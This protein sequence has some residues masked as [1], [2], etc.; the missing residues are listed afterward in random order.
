M[1]HPQPLLWWH[2]CCCVHKQ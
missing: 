1:S 2:K